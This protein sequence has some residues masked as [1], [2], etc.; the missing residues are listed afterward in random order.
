MKDLQKIGTHWA[1]DLRQCR[2]GVMTFLLGNIAFELMGLVPDLRQVTLK[3][4]L[5]SKPQKNHEAHLF[6]Q[7]PVGGG[8]FQI[9]CHAEWG[10]LCHISVANEVHQNLI[11]IRHILQ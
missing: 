9:W 10:L 2:C 7:D 4:C 8:V 5:S 6:F 11:F 3:S 1:H